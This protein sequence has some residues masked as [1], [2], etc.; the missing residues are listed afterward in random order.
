MS[1]LKYTTNPQATTITHILSS[2]TLVRISWQ[3]DVNSTVNITNIGTNLPL[4]GYRDIT[5][6]ASKLFTVQATNA[7]GTI[8][9]RFINII[10]QQNNI[11]YQQELLYE[12]QTPIYLQ[13]SIQKLYLEV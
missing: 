2:N 13:D 4:S 5:I 6:S 10:Y 1:N 8:S 11:V 9:Q 12:D 7:A 3:A